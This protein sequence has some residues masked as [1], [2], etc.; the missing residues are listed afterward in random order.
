MKLSNQ[1]LL[2]FTL[3]ILLSVADSYTNYL[4]SKK[5]QLNSLFLARSEEIIRN[6]NKTHKAIIEMQSAFRG[7]LLTDDKAFLNSYFK[8]LKNVPELIKEQQLRIG[9]HNKQRIILDSIRNMHNNWLEY[10]A[11]IIYSREKVPGSYKNLFENSLKKTR[12]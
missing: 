7:Y 9:T 6:S 3:I 2:A 12:R 4:L 5:V 1:I 10:S 8:G 11:Q